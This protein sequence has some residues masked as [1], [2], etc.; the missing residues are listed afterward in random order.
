MTR[1]DADLRPVTAVHMRHNGMGDLVWHAEYFRLVAATSRDGQVTIVVPPSTMARELLGH[2]PWVREVIDYDRRPRRSEGR[3]GRH[4]GLTGPLRFGAVLAPLGLERMVLFSDRPMRTLVACF[5]AGIRTRLGYGN[6]W[7]QR[8]LLTRSRWIELYNGPAVGLYHDAS[9]FAM[10]QGW[11]TAPVVPRLTVRTDAVRRMR[12]RLASLP[13]PLHVLAI[14]AS[15]AYKQWGARNFSALANLLATRGHGVV[16]LGGPAETA[17]AREILAGMHP[18]LRTKV[19]ALTD[20]TVSD[21][22]AVLSLAQSCIGNDTGMTN[23]AAAVGTS[24]YVVLGPRP[25]LE[26][27]P[28]R[29]TLLQAPALSDIRA[30]LVAQRV[31]RLETATPAASTPVAMTGSGFN[32]PLGAA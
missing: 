2:E 11:C 28:G 17:L 3:Q 24:T 7:L 21:S 6:T 13:W 22:A 4:S 31:L 32:R 12:A 19:L 9:R 5:R 15:E 27:D 8:R 1:P 10:A 26:H 25:P 18:A 23:I 29:M 30:D 16:L 20:T 14:G